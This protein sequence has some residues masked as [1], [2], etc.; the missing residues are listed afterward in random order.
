MNRLI[1]VCLH[2]VVWLALGNV[3]VLTL[4]E[5]LRLTIICLGLLLALYFYRKN[6]KGAASREREA[7]S[8]SILLS[9]SLCFAITQFDQTS[10][11]LDSDFPIAFIASAMLIGLAFI[12]FIWEVFSLPR[13]KPLGFLDKLILYCLAG[14]SALNFI[15]FFVFGNT[16]SYESIIWIQVKLLEY[17]AIWIICNQLPVYMDKEVDQKSAIL[18]SGQIGHMMSAF[19]LNTLGP[20]FISL[21]LV[22]SVGVLGGGY[23]IFTLLDYGRKA[24]VA[25]EQNRLSLAKEYLTRWLVVSEELESY[26]W[27][28]QTSNYEKLA[29]VLIAKGDTTNALKVINK[30]GSRIVDEQENLQQ[31][32][33]MNYNLGLWSSAINA[34][35]ELLL[36]DPSNELIKERLARCF[37]RKKHYR[38]L[39]LQLD[40][41]H[42]F[43]QVE[44]E[45][46]DDY[47]ILGTILL[48]QGKF[49]PASVLLKKAIKIDS[50]NPIA[51]YQLGRALR[52][53]SEWEGA[54][55]AFGDAINISP[56][57]TDS[58]YQQGNI[59][60]FSK[61]KNE[62]CTAYN[63]T[64]NALPT[65]LEAY[66]AMRRLGCS[67]LDYHNNIDLTN[68]TVAQE[69]MGSDIV[70]VG[71]ELDMKL[72]NRA[73]GLDIKLVWQLA[74]DTLDTPSRIHYR[75]YRN[76]PNAEKYVIVQ[77]GPYFDIAPSSWDFG[78]VVSTDIYHSFKD[79][80]KIENGCNYVL[81][82]KLMYYE[83]Y[84]YTKQFFDWSSNVWS[85][86]ES[87]NISDLCIT[88]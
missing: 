14:V 87:F 29:S 52:D 1:I 73:E 21:L 82:L 33:R 60:E 55:E 53:Q 15:T 6:A 13:W 27:S 68:I 56:E 8:L 70:L 18:R 67:E 23:K 4:G 80:K 65:H 54:Y 88:N 64:L 31:V 22:F 50:K 48:R 20:I 75:L 58:R 71:Y 57:F 30:I 86:T 47:L 17:A 83:E 9:G 63:A 25:F 36:L 37:L 16:G 7:R 59:L 61:K 12:L 42:E 81:E 46:Y 35:E 39:A 41:R 79:L 84:Q 77:K 51:Y 26:R 85:Y 45:N 44:G 34:F 10:K 19:R 2:L 69:S 78:Q 43:L 11:N 74:P 72:F 28:L 3:L 38:A 40:N 24:V 62:A 66:R 49:L 5:Y 76:T 32:G